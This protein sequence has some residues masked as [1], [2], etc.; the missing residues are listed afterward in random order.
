MLADFFNATTGWVEV[1][2]LV[3]ALIAAGTIVFMQGGLRVITRHRR[4][5]QGGAPDPYAADSED[6]DRLLRL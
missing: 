3:M 1:L 5:N 2:L 6:F 4:R